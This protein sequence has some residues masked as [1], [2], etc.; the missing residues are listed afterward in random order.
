MPKPK[1]LSNINW[2]EVKGMAEEIVNEKTSSDEND[3]DHA[4]NIHYIY[5]EVMEAI[6]GPDIWTYLNQ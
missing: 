6:Y 4:D 1:P 2:D 5:E 3:D